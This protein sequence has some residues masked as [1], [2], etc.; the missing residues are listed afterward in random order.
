MFA[1]GHYNYALSEAN[2]EVYAWGMG[3]NYVLGTRDDENEFEPKLVHPKQFMENRVKHVGAGVQHVV[4]LTTAEQ[5]PT[6]SLPPLD[7]TAMSTKFDMPKEEDKKNEKEDKPEEEVKRE[8]APAKEEA[9]AKE[10]VNEAPKIAE[11]AAVPEEV[12]VLSQ[13]SEPKARSRG[14][15]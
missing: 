11:V 2:N 7:Q 4:V 5:E 1:Q 13:K 15:S 9:P 6:S 10:L 14:M 3:E 8:S 12:K